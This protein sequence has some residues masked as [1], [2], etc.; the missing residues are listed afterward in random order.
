MFLRFTVALLHNLKV[1]KVWKMLFIL[2]FFV[3][4]QQL[5]M[6]NK[7]WRLWFQLL[8]GLTCM[9]NLTWHSTQQ[10]WSISDLQNLWHKSSFN[11]QLLTQIE[12][13]HQTFDAKLQLLTLK[14]HF[15]MTH[16]ARL[17]TFIIKLWHQN[18]I[19]KF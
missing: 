6:F 17:S 13:Q 11:F 18:Y 2:N 9:T 12:F 14:I 1:S 8:I 10:P 19:T 15:S 16:D 4:L 5:Q 3:F 7:W